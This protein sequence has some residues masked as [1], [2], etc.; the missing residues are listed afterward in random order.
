M[1]DWADE[2]EGNLSD[3]SFLFD[4]RA[5]ADD[6]VTAEPQLVVIVNDSPKLNKY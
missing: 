4:L 6:L 1:A 5:Y 3:F 2:L